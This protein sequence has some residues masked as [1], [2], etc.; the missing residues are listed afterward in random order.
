MLLEFIPVVLSEVMLTTKVASEKAR[1]AAYECL[2]AMGRKM[3]EV[4]IRRSRDV[5]WAKSRGGDDEMD[6]EEREI[7]F[8]DA[9][10]ACC[11]RLVF[12]FHDVMGEELVKEIVSTILIFMSSNNR[13]IVKAALG[14]IKVVVVSI[15]QELLEDELE[16]MITSMLTMAKPLKSHFKAKVK[17][18]LEHLI[19]KFSPRTSIKKAEKAAKGDESDDENEAAQLAIKSKK[20][21]QSRQKEFE[22]VLHGNDDHYI[23]EQFKDAVQKKT[24]AGS[25]NM[26]HEG[27]DIVDFLDS[28]VISNVTSARGGSSSGSSGLKRKKGS[29]FNMNED[30]RIMIAETDDEASS[31]MKNLSTNDEPQE[32]YY[33]EALTS[34]GSYKR[35]PDG[36]VKFVTKRKR[37]DDE[38]I[39]VTGGRWGAKFDKK[40]K[41]TGM[42]EAAKTKMLGGDYRSKRAKGDVM[43]ANAP[44]PFAFIP[45]SGKL[46][47]SKKK[48][49]ELSKDYKDVFKASITGGAIRSN[50][51]G[52]GAAGAAG[53]GRQGP[54]GIK[55]SNK[56]HK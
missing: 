49:T 37:D 34:E 54:R 47:G 8:R 13:E 44:D 51:Q 28:R 45:L 15:R 26:I 41:P 3:L 16:N 17:N 29:D 2:I 39:P 18:A 42:D 7:N 31:G 27:E 46:V 21:M 56:K 55:K 40:K 52:G 25:K 12:E 24:A 35:L 23:P 20:T 10:I 11:G 36:S 4:G 30:G 1:S 33:K 19:R 9:A 32:D 50:N 5:E 43:K 22:D 14:F 48:S 6:E 38:D 53:A